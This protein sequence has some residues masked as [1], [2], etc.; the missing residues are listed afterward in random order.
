MRLS[1]SITG[2]LRRSNQQFPTLPREMWSNSSPM[3][4]ENDG[5]T[6]I[7]AEVG[8]K[9]QMLSTATSRAWLTRKNAPKRDSPIDK[10]TMATIKGATKEGNS[11]AES[12]GQ[13]ILSPPWNPQRKTT[14]QGPSMIYSSYPAHSIR[15]VGIL[16]PSATSLGSMA[17][18]RTRARMTKTSP[19]TKMIRTRKTRATLATFS[20]QKG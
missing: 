18:T 12:K 19:K 20:I 4:S 14:C 9:P 16:L 15:K 8:L 13:T 11:Q 6:R 17:S 1:E 10:I 3:A 7:F 2:D 5:N